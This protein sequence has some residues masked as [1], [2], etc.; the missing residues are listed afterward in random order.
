VRF[1]AVAKLSFAMALWGTV[2]CN[3]RAR[4]AAEAAARLKAA[5]A[6]RDLEQLFTA[7][8]LETRWSWMTV[9]RAQREAYDIVLSNYPEGPARE[10]QLRRFAPGALADSDVALFEQVF[11]ASEWDQ[12]TRDLG[13]A[14]TAAPESTS[15]D[16]ARLP[17][18]GAAEG[19]L[20][21]KLDSKSDKGAG[22]KGHEPITPQG[23]KAAAPPALLFRRGEDGS[24]GFAGLASLAEEEKR[25]A[26][27]DL[28][29][30]RTD[31]A[32]LERAATRAG[33]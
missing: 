29:L 18:A 24:W 14:A 3:D 13:A 17:I 19:N 25:R 7:L 27:A 21:A 6:A 12:L 4:T 31:A 23:R 22:R 28:E 32:D 10:Q 9:R 16:E 15:E 1:G 11:P 5:V 2:G 33:R 26:T 20:D 30:V 8:D